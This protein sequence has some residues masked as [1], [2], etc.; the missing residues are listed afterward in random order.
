M[1]LDFRLLRVGEVGSF[2]CVAFVPGAVDDAQ[3]RAAAVFISR[4]AFGFLE[5]SLEAAW[6]G[7][8]RQASKRE[9]YLSAEVCEAF[10]AHLAALRDA[11]CGADSTVAVGGLALM[12]PALQ[13]QMQHDGADVRISL[14]QQIEALSAW[15]REP[16]CARAGVRLVQL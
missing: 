10:L 12:M 9:T 16:P 13:A 4:S 3:A 8:A 14:A 7:Y 11:L 1:R 5:A 2:P 15:L 6:P